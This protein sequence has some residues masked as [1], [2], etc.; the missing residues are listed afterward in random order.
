MRVYSVQM[1]IAGPIN[2]RFIWR[3]VAVRR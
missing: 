2:R 1:T 3:P